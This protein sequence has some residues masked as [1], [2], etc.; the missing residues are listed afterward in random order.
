[1][2]RKPGR[3]RGAF[4]IFIMRHGIAARKGSPPGSGDAKRP[5]TAKGKKRTEQ[6]AAG[7][8]R[9]GCE[10]DWI[11]TSPLVR[12]AQTAEIVAASLSKKVS[13]DVCAALRPGGSAEDLLSFMAKNPDRKSVLL[14]GHEPDL[15]EL[16]GRLIG[17]GSK[18]NL[19]F[20]KGGCCCIEFDR[21]PSRSTGHLLWWLTPRLLRA[22]K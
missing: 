6:I 1:L 14:V 15:G 22:I 11:V 9:L 17:A 19:A 10:V 5:L 16:A 13:V 2:L 20:K 8:N 4:Q 3:D 21:H 12:A 7:L 18:A